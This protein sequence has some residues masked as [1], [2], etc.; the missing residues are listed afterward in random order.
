M[1]MKWIYWTHHMV[2][3]YF[4]VN[5]VHKRLNYGGVN[6]GFVFAVDV[7]GNEVWDRFIF[8]WIWCLGIRTMGN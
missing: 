6:D 1:G 5:V 7:G 2:D 8:C 4:A 3:C